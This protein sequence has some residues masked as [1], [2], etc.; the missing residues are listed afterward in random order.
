MEDLEFTPYFDDE[1]LTD[2]LTRDDGNTFSDYK[3]N[4]SVA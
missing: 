3:V 4:G 1:A 2:V